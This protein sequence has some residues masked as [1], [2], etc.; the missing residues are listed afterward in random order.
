[1]CSCESAAHAFIAGVAAVLLAML[2]AYVLGIEFA[3][4]DDATH[5]AI[6]AGALAAYALV[7]ASHRA[8]SPPSCV[9]G[10]VHGAVVASYSV[11]AAV[12]WRVAADAAAAVERD[13][14]AA[15]ATSA[16]AYRRRALSYT[17]VG[18]ALVVVAVVRVA[19][20]TWFEH[21]RRVV[22][23]DDDEERTAPRYSV[24]H[25]PTARA[26]A[27]DESTRTSSHDS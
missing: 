18:T 14:Y 20:T 21:A 11:V 1:M 17:Y 25:A 12:Y 9:R 23:V 4:D 5:H 2:G 24:E 6:G 7:G 8:Y 19:S 26:D 27:N 3:H 15:S 13:E 16:F 22:H 10:I